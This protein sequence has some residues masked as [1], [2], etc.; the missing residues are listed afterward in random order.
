[1][2][3]RRQYCV[4]TG[5]HAK[6]RELLRGQCT[7]GLRDTVGKNDRRR[8]AHDGSHLVVE[9]ETV[10]TLL[11]ATAP[12]ASEQARQSASEGEQASEP[13]GLLAERDDTEEWFAGLAAMGRGRAGGGVSDRRRRKRKILKPPVGE[14][15]FDAPPEPWAIPTVTHTRIA[16]RTQASPKLGA[17]TALWAGVG[18]FAA[19]APRMPWRHVGVGMAC[20]LLC[21]V[22]GL[23]VLG[24]RRQ[25]V[26]VVKHGVLAA[27][28]SRPVRAG[29]RVVPLRRR[30]RRWVS[31]R[32]R[33]RTV[34]RP[35]LRPMS[36]VSQAPRVAPSPPVA[37]TVV[38]SPS[39][40]EA[41][42]PRATTPRP[43][44]NQFAYLGQ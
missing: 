21:V 44:A 11:L 17:W 1:M 31:A 35:R 12:E 7:H 20:V 27:Q 43:A 14:L 9:R 2:W 13:A 6:W 15:A 30:L 4:T 5:G 28:A 19:R 32:P 39:T 34:A 26:A 42:V 33:A 37:V 36:R 25:G 8:N 38:R 16:A 24:S 23:R 3:W 18:V 10:L 29:V 41:A 40:S 22:I